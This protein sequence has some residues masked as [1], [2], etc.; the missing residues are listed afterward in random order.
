MTQSAPENRAL[1]RDCGM[2]LGA[3]LARCASCGSP[4]LVRHPELDRLAIAHIDCDA[5]YAAIEKRDNPEL[6]DV[7]L[8][9]GGGQRGVVSTCCY[10]AR[11]YGVRSAMPM[12]K[13]LEACPDAVVIKPNMEKYAKVGKE[14]RER[15]LA[16]T[17]LVEPISIDE[18][19][20]D[21][22]GTQR[23]HHAT[24]A[25]TLAGFI[26][27]IERDIGITA[28][29][30]LAPNKFLAKLASDLEKPRGFSVI[31]AAEA[32]AVLAA[33]P[34]GRIWGVGKVFQQKLERDGIST[35]GQL[36]TVDAADLARRYG[37]IGLR[38]A[39]LAQGE[40]ARLVTPERGA[41]SVSSETTFRTDIS[42]FQTLRPILRDLS[43]KVSAR[44]KKSGLSGRGITLKLKTSDF[45]TITRARH[46][47]DPTQL[48]DKI[49]SAGVDLLENETNGRKFRLIGIGV[50]DLETADRADPRDLLDQSAERRKNAELAVD[51]LRDKFGKSAIELGLTHVTRTA[52]KP[53]KT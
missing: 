37:S 9:I 23:L 33:M 32:K 22:T 46:L 51:R 42:S 5:F 3:T 11:I 15:M 4:R 50:S 27:A 19:F 28:S 17:P 12:F 16:L 52:E 30:G 31:G 29:V 25:E 47:S 2:R 53:K 18:A 10:I 35:I 43:E 20:L 8:I 7:P 38:L 49:Y 13:A 36:Q 26:R 40:D 48:A 34:V 21:L 45:K 39:Q 6:Q 44:L 41:K 24:P 1:C 14:I